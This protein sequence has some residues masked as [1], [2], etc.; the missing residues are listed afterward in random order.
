MSFY[1]V[2]RIFEKQGLKLYDVEKLTTH[3]GSLRIYATHIENESIHILYSVDCLI[4]EEKKFGL[5]D[6]N[7]Y[8]NFQEKADKVKYDL[9][10]FLLQAKKNNEKVVGYGAAAKGNTLLNYARGEKN[11]N[12]TTGS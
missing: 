9:L 10:E 4:E 7:I 1:T 11:S 2:K 12:Q 5:F 8:K 6:T 3:G